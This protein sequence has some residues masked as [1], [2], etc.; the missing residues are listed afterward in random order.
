MVGRDAA[1]SRVM[2][3]DCYRQQQRRHPAGGI[4][5]A[6][7]CNQVSPCCGGCFCVL[8][9]F[10]RREQLRHGPPEGAEDGERND[11]GDGDARE[12]VA[13]QEGRESG[14]DIPGQGMWCTQAAR[15]GDAT[16]RTGR[17]LVTTSTSHRDITQ[18][19]P[20]FYTFRKKLLDVPNGGRGPGHKAEREVVPRNIRVMAV[21]QRQLGHTHRRDGNKK[22]QKAEGHRG[23]WWDHPRPGLG[24]VGKLGRDSDRHVST[25]SRPP[26]F[27]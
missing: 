25:A 24:Q 7:R 26:V 3:G 19:M 16:T 10:Q 4:H 17:E 8:L 13:E 2:G 5:G 1:P 11:H 9:S 21:Q 14:H 20:A 22:E 15:R 27:G 6:L 23:G 18:V 12:E